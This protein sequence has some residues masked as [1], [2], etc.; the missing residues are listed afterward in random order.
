MELPE[1]TS[2]AAEHLAG[3]PVVLRG[4]ERHGCCG[5]RA[6]LPVAEI[7]PPAQPDHYRQV[8]DRGRTWY[9]DPRLAL[10]VGGWTVEVAGLGR[11]RRLHLAGATPLDVPSSGETL[12]A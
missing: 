2:A 7:G 12:D 1:L 10:L 6:L 11:W 4:S 9:V 8:T 5:G 3:R